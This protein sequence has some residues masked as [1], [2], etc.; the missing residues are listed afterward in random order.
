M[1]SSGSIAD[2]AETGQLVGLVPAAT[3]RQQDDGSLSIQ[4]RLEAKVECPAEQL[5]GRLLCGRL[6]VKV[7]FVCPCVRLGGVH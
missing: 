1:A 6:P 7:F 3:L 5:S 4:M 2:I